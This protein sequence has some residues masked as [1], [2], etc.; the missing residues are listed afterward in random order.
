MKAFIG[1]TLLYSLSHE[2]ILQRAQLETSEAIQGSCLCILYVCMCL[3][4]CASNLAC[5]CVFVRSGKS[6][7]WIL[8]SCL[9]DRK[10]SSVKQRG[11]SIR[12]C[13][14]S[15]RLLCIFPLHTL[16][17]QAHT[18]NVCWFTYHL[19]ETETHFTFQTKPHWSLLLL[20]F[21]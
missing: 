4:L 13:Y 16:G 17:L 1:Q 21:Q 20:H 7:V 15:F 2:L 14:A 19:H 10:A 5:L 12:Q 3:L 6:G 11:R 8:S 18:N 9:S